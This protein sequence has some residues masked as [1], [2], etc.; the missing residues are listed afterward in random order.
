MKSRR[1]RCC[2]VAGE[3]EE[4]ERRSRRREK[5]LSCLQTSSGSRARSKT[6][7]GRYLR[8]IVLKS[9]VEVK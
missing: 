5:G 1:R 8:D 3:E 2:M 6:T 7:E 4:E 9:T